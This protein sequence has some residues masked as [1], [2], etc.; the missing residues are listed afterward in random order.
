MKKKVLLVG[1]G[2]HCKS[3]IDVIENS[4]D[5][6]VFGIIDMPEKV[7]EII[8][9]YPV[10]GTDDDLK[11]FIHQ[12]DGA[13]ITVGHIK[14]NAVRV[15][16]FNTLK[17][18][19]YQLPVLVSNLAYVSKHAIV[20]EGTIVMH[21]A[22]VNAGA[23]IGENCILNTKS[24]IE[25]D[26]QVGNHCHISTTAVLNGDVRI[27]NDCFVGSGSVINQTVYIT[28]NCLIASNTLIR[29]DLKKSGVFFQN[30]PLKSSYVE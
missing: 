1:G 4:K 9:G 30:I 18:L 26:V 13:H 5:W 28:N 3:C 22:I 14:S 16:L 27:G 24:L 10:V 6:E 21:H 12:V 8:C 11:N 15:K 19:G 20:G 7:G 2:G 23:Q 29:K 17:S 25:H